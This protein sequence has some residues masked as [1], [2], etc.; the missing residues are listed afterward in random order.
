M[1]TEQ[2]ELNF[3]CNGKER[4]TTH[5]CAL[6]RHPHSTTGLY[7]QTLHGSTHQARAATALDLLHNVLAQLRG[8]ADWVEAAVEVV[9]GEEEVV[10]HGRVIGSSAVVAPAVGQDLDELLVAGQ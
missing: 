9:G 7:H 8:A 10:A 3:S 2:D 5:L 4:T 1:R 6:H